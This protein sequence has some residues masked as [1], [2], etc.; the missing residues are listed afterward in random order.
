[1]K[2]TEALEIL[3]LHAEDDDAPRDLRN[4]V[5]AVTDYFDARAAISAEDFAAAM[6]RWKRTS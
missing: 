3:N 2:I 5:K 6:E 1:M 4:A